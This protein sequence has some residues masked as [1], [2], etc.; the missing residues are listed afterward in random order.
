MPAGSLVPQPRHVHPR[1]GGSADAGR[2]QWPAIRGVLEEILLAEMLTRV[3]ATVL[4][5][6]DRRQGTL[7]AEPIAGAS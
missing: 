6:F 4:C 1:A 5:A 3:W 2:R 7:E